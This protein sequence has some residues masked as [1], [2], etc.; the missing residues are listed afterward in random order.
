[1]D[2]I[3]SSL[4]A[5][6]SNR[7]SN[8][9]SISAP[10]SLPDAEPSGSTGG[11]AD[12]GTLRGIGQSGSPG[13]VVTGVAPHPRSGTDVLHDNVISNRNLGLEELI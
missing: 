2:K 6:S 13:V 3:S 12:L 7:L 8:E 9:S 1:M 4:L 10:Q 5:S 11:D